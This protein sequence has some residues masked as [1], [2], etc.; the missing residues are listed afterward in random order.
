MYTIKVVN[1]IE[2][3][4][5]AEWDAMIDDNVFA[6]YGWLKT[7][8]ETFAGPLN[9]KYIL[10]QNSNK[11]AGAAVCYVF[12][13]TCDIL[14]SLDDYV[15]RR[16][17]KLVSKMGISFLPAFICC[18]LKCYGKHFLVDD[19]VDANEKGIIMSILLEAIEKEASR[20]KLP[21]SFTCVMDSETELIQLLNKNG[22]TTTSGYLLAYL[23]I[24]WSSFE[25]Y[26][27]HVRRISKNMKGHIVKQINKNRKEGVI[28]KRLEG[29]DGYEDRLYEL[30]NNNYYKHNT[31]LFPFKREF[32]RKLKHNLGEDAVIY[33]SVKNGRVTGVADLLKRNKVGYITFVGI[34]HEMAGNDFTYF[35][36]GYYRPIA[37][38]ISNKIKRLYTGTMMYELKVN[39]GCKVTNTYIFHKP[40][41]KITKIAIKP[42]FALVT[43][44][45]KLKMT[46]RFMKKSAIS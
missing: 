2:D 41:H 6:S 24:E 32:L 20:A 27:N 19:K 40:V 25:G 36:I 43:I 10:V 14:P 16:Y 33:I 30:L 31:K 29:L 28:I 12:N 34:D 4:K 26:K 9:P 37:D 45:Y 11:L 23:D 46:K 5:R 8:E 38:A 35:N 13:K 1:S 15:F 3:V 39:R 42:W 21:V 17:K 7:V 44:Q 18:P 22:Y